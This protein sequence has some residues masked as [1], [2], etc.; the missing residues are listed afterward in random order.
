MA[1]VRILE[2]LGALHSAIRQ[3]DFKEITRISGELET[4]FHAPDQFAEADLEKIRR[5]SF[6]VQTCLGAA[7]QGM[8]SA[9]QRLADIRA[10]GRLVTYDNQGQRQ[11]HTVPGQAKRI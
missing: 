5:Q 3:A 9:R 8:R 7:L 10:A 2:S 1:E 4:F 11:S 6:A